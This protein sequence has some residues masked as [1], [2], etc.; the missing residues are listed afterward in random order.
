[1]LFFIWN[2]WLNGKLIHNSI[3]AKYAVFEGGAFEYFSKNEYIS[4]IL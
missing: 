3:S 2:L 4:F 1:M